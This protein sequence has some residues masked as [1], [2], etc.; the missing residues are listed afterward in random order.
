MLARAAGTHCTVFDNVLC[1]FEEDRMINRQF[2]I[3]LSLLT[4]LAIFSLVNIS[5]ISEKHD[6]R[7][8]RFPKSSFF[9]EFSSSFQKIF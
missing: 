6:H 9:P 4:F 3:L 8:S 2:E 5:R 7:Y 1:I